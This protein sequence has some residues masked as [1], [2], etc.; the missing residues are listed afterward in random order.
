MNAF[1]LLV[2]EDNEDDLNVSRDSLDRYEHETKREIEV[3]ECKTVEEAFERLD[4]SFD[5]AIID[6]KL[7]DRGDEGNEVINR[8]VESQFRIP[9]AVLT[10][11]PDSANSSFS[12]IGVFK[13]GETTYSQLLD[14]FWG[15]HNS[16]LTRIMG[17]RGVIEQTLNRVFLEN[18]LPQ[19]DV[20]VAYGNAD[21]SRTESALLRHT[22]NHLLQ[23]L[24][25][26]NDRC[27]PEEA[28]IYPPLVKTLKT[29][30]IVTRKADKTSFVVLNPA[31]DLVI[32]KNKDSKT[33]R[34]LLVEV[35]PGKTILET[36]LN[37]ITK[38]DKRT[39]KLEDVFRNNYTD[40]LHWL[41]ETKLGFS[42][43]RFLNFRKISTMSKEDFAKAFN[44]PDVQ[45][46]PSF[47]KD[48]VARFST[49]YARQGQPDIDS[50]DIINR[51]TAPAG[52]P[53]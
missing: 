48:I 33:D 39:A 40:Y 37:G 35:E 21:S 26:E 31:C 53:K 50:V 47:I 16:G 44:A 4:S 19:I 2:V 29:G 15:I 7:G 6:L 51:L 30:S 22:L 45:I 24:D 9:I 34:I 38:K 43:S 36:A 11:T 41:P 1:R 27:F 13:K 23:L 5:G 10:G 3:I 8:I 52:A 42:E 25:D 46:S 14:R 20:W 18:L 49:Y 28:Y 17:G 12:Y 32:R